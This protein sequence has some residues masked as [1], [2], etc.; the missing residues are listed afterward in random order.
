M[1]ASALS[2]WK[3]FEVFR[4]T[5]FFA[6]EKGHDLLRFFFE[7]LEDMSSKN[8]AMMRDTKQNM[9]RFYRMI[10]NG[11]LIDHDNLFTASN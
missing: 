1:S 2:L 11:T 3:T 6:L 7:E 5:A 9:L 10:F 4:F 8:K